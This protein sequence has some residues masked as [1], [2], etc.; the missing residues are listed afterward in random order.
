MNKDNN[1]GI[2]GLCD[3]SQGK[4][5]FR[6]RDVDC[7]ERS[8]K[9]LSFL[10]IYVIAE[11]RDRVDFCCSSIHLALDTFGLIWQTFMVLCNIKSN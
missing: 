1:I 6:H 9:K 7:K 2:T 3:I 8:K 5:K 11:I 10:R 4:F